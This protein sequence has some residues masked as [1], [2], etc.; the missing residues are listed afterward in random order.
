MQLNP[1][2]KLLNLLLAIPSAQ[3]LCD[4]FHIQ[5]SGN[6]NKSLGTLCA[7]AD[8]TFE[9]FLQALEK[10]DWSDDYNSQATEL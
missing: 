5:V 1:E 8:I 7:E 6:Q 2:T 4:R 3:L 9:T 10:L